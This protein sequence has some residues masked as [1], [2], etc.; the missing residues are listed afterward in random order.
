MRQIFILLLSLAF[1]APAS[2]GAA[3]FD[4]QELLQFLRDHSEEL[5]DIVNLGERKQRMTAARKSWEKPKPFFATA[6]GR[7]FIGP[8][9]ALQLVVFTDFTCGHC[10]RFYKML[11]KMTAKNGPLHNKVRIVMKF[12]P[13]SNGGMGALPAAVF[14][15]AWQT[16]PEYAWKFA[17]LIYAEQEYLLNEK[18]ALWSLEQKLALSGY[19]EPHG[20]IEKARKGMDPGGEIRSLIEEDLGEA[21]RNGINGT[22]ASY[23]G[24]LYIPGAPSEEFVMEA[25]TKASAH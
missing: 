2:A 21:E 14:Y 10:K 9:N 11:K 13:L 22:P 4:E 5:V 3:S 18:M 15:A 17:D 7:P 12:A 16:N 24:N 25:Y 23:M 19:S 8:D 1:F 6:A 20:I